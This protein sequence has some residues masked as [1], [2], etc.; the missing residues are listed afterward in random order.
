MLCQCGG[1]ADAQ[2][3][4]VN[5]VVTA[6]VGWSAVVYLIGGYNGSTG[7]QGPVGP[8]GPT[9]PTS[10]FHVV[11]GNAF[12]RNA[13]V[14]TTDPYSLSVITNNQTRL[15]FGATGGIQLPLKQTLVF[16][17]AAGST[18]TLIAPTTLLANY[19]IQLPVNAPP[20]AESMLVADTTGATWWQPVLPPYVQMS[21]L[22]A[23][24]I[25]TT[26]GAMLPDTILTIPLS[27]VYQI[28][29]NAV[30]SHSSTSS[31]AGVGMQLYVNGNAV[32]TAFSIV[33]INTPTFSTPPGGATVALSTVV[34]G[35]LTSQQIGVYWKIYQTGTGTC[36]ARTL[37][38]VRLGPG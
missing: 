17:D 25:T 28:T 1:K 4:V 36:S 27:G 20:S 5:G 35:V 24:T 33:N 26:T 18:A 22:T 23:A 2:N 19:T 34:T 14:G 15:T 6:N 30:V 37:I 16:R 38:A 11:T 29:F 21:S 32:P 8:I 9:P 31:S 12:S 7:A 3:T 10:Q 13:S